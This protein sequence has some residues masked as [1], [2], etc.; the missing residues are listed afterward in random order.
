MP[1]SRDISKSG[2]V[3]LA[4]RNTNNVNNEATGFTYTSQC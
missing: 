2:K 3:I 1:K 4:H